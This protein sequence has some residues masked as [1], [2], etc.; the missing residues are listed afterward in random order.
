MTHRFYRAIYH[1]S[2]SINRLIEFRGNVRHESTNTIKLT[3]RS[4]ILFNRILK[5]FNIRHKC[6]YV[7]WNDFNEILCHHWTFVQ[8]LLIS[9]QWMHNSSC[10]ITETES[11]DAM[12]KVLG[13]FIKQGA[14]VNVSLWKMKTFKKKRKEKIDVCYANME[15]VLIDFSSTYFFRQLYE[16]FQLLYSTLVYPVWSWNFSI[17]LCRKK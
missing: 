9:F 13:G 2:P 12:G 15:F 8:Y 14:N 3:D 17:N 6:F 11:V 16:N 4:N 5:C 10:S 7:R 1:I